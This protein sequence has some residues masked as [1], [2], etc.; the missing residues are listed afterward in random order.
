MNPLPK[1]P[2]RESR[3]LGSVGVGLPEK[4]SPSTRSRE[5][6]KEIIVGFFHQ[7]NM[8]GILLISH[9]RRLAD[10]LGELIQALTNNTLM[11]CRIGGEET[12][13]VDTG[14]V[15]QEFEILK[16]KG[17]HAVL[18]FGDSGS[19]FMAAQTACD[20]WNDDIIDIRIVDAPFVEESVAAAMVLSTG[21]GVDQAMESA[22]EAYQI[23]KC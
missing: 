20:L 23:H 1:S 19:A 6:P 16:T 2:V 7:A 17:C 22:Q 21:G 10:G 4:G 14:M 9:S 15:L 11:I 12:L 13:G 3:T 5:K 8:I 18:V